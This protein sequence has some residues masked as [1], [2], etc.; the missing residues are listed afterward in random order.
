[1]GLS[2]P[3]ERLEQLQR[4]LVA[5]GRPGSSAQ[6]AVGQAVA[7]RLKAQIKHQFATGTGPDGAPQL[8][9][10][11]DGRP[12]LVSRKL[13]NAVKV[14]VTDQGLVGS[15]KVD[16]LEAHQHGH[17]WPP[18]RAQGQRLMQDARGRF[19][20]FSRFVHLASVSTRFQNGAWDGYAQRTR[21]GSWRYVAARVRAAVHMVGSR[22]LQPRLVYPEGALTSPWAHAIAEGIRDGLTA[23]FQ[24]ATR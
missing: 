1:M 22:I 9:R 19:M 15:S 12:G 3:F 4:Q 23:F 6:R 20:S 7:K 21:E 2:G 10:K 5:L 17:T 24:R 11:K 8:A 18:R 16:W 14:Q 13:G